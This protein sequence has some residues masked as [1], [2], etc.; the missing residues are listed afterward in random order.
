MHSQESEDDFK[1]NTLRPVNGG[2]YLASLISLSNSADH[3]E[4]NL[5]GKTSV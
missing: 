5:W 3:Q 4:N 1:L 2:L